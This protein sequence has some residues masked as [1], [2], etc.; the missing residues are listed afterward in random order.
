[1]NLYL[2]LFIF[3]LL[4]FGRDGAVKGGI[5][6]VGEIASA[7]RRPLHR[8]LSF[9]VVSANAICATGPA[10]AEGRA[11]APLLSGSLNR[12]QGRRRAGISL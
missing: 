11:S 2:F 9:F 1:M 12:G 6:F 5:V 3:F 10:S 8:V 7:R 4:S